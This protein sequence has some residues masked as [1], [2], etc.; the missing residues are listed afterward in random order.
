VPAFDD[1]DLMRVRS[2]I[3]DAIGDLDELPGALAAA[4]RRLN[5]AHVVIG[6]PTFDARLGHFNDALST[7]FDVSSSQ[8][9]AI[10]SATL[11][12]WTEGMLAKFGARPGLILIGD[13]MTPRD[14]VLKSPWQSGVFIPNDMGDL[15]TATLRPVDAYDAPVA[16]LGIV[17]SRRSPRFEP[18]SADRLA[19]FVRDLERMVRVAL[20]LRAHE[21][22]EVLLRAT[23]DRAVEAF[24]IVR[25]NLRIVF[26]NA[27][28]ESMLDAGGDLAV[29][30]GKL[31][32]AGALASAIT[33]AIERAEGSDVAIAREGRRPLLVTVAP[34]PGE[35]SERLDAHAA[36]ILVVS[37]PERSIAGPEAIAQA[38]AL[39]EAEAHLAHQISRGSSVAEFAARYA[40]SESTV[41]RQFESILRKLALTNSADLVRLLAALPISSRPQPNEA[42]PDAQ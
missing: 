22:D 34:A 30:N 36:A 33:R 7:S 20:A 21:N 40:V 17:R 2:R 25:G 29:R 28:A 8:A 3:Y 14:A 4:G 16:M 10:D 35:M 26:A 5:G 24:L 18:D 32:A 15:L 37:D 31:V 6:S 42:S 19:L 38:F 23:L 13:Q 12:P 41:H 9:F 39:S 27:A 1:D 11:D